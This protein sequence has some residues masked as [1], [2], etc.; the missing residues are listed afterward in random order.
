MVTRD[1]GDDLQH[2]GARRPTLTTRY[3]ERYYTRIGSRDADAHRDA[4]GMVYGDDYGR[5]RG[6]GR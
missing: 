5:R 6:H 1:S 3:K 4:D 2:G